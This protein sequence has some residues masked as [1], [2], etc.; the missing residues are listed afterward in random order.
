MCF[1]SF[2]DP[3]T[4]RILDPANM[5]VVCQIFPQSLK[6]AEIRRLLCYFGIQLLLGVTSP[7]LPD[8]AEL[9]DLARV[10]EKEEV[11]WRGLTSQGGLYTAK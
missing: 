6:G 8:L 2:E 3:G 1:P 9:V 10:I 4:S 5:V 7:D 11:R